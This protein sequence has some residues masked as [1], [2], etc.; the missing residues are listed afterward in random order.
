MKKGMI[1]SVLLMVLVSGCS[2]TRLFLIDHNGVLTYNRNTGQLEIIWE[3]RERP[4]GVGRDSVS[5]V[6]NDSINRILNYNFSKD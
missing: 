4:N 5:S 3:W 2:Q 1:L 6:K